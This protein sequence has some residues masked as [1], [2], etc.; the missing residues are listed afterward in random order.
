MNKL[1]I[2]TGDYKLKE[3]TNKDCA[4]V[5]LGNKNIIIVTSRYS[6]TDVEETNIATIS[7]DSLNTY[8][9]ASVLPSELLRQRDELIKGVKEIETKSFIQ[10]KVFYDLLIKEDTKNPEEIENLKEILRFID[11]LKHDAIE[12]L[13]SI[14]NE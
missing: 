7:C 10:R 12:L 5:T 11:S 4:G 6:I 8:Q 3:A 14:E 9:K 13:K 1:N 2:T